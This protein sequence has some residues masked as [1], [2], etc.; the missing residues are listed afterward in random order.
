MA[1]KKTLA[2]SSLA[3]VMDRILDKGVVVD[4]WARVSLLGVELRAMETRQ[5]GVGVSD[6]LRY[7]EAIGLTVKAQDSY[8]PA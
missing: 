1:V 6:Y 4:S 2:S 5:A 8:P 3:D 7:A